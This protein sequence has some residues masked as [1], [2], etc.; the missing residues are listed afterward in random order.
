MFFF[1]Q[2]N[3]FPD[4]ATLFMNV[5]AHFDASRRQVVAH[6]SQILNHPFLCIH[7]FYYGPCWILKFFYYIQGLLIAQFRN[8]ARHP[9]DIFLQILDQPFILV[10]KLRLALVELGVDIPISIKH[11]PPGVFWGDIPWCCL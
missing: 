10:R 3:K 9:P 2:Y 11:V 7:F 5:L 4:I 8:E 6:K 1:E